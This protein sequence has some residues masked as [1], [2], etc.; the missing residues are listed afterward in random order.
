[1]ANDGAVVIDVLLDSAKAMTEYNK[2]GSVMSGTGSKIGSALKAGTAAAIAGTA[3]VG[4]AAVGIGKQVLASYADYEQL[5]GGVDTLFGNASKT[6]Q[7]FADNAY[8]TAGLSA[9][10]YM[11]TVTGFSASMVA[12]LK[13][14]TA[15]AADYSNQAVVDM[16]DNA[17]KMGSNIGDIQ[18]AY[19]GFAKQNYTML[20]NLK[21]GYGGTQ[22]E[23]KRLLSD[24]EKF[25]GQKY[26][27]SSFADVTQAIHVVQTQMGITGTTA[28][29]A[30]S[31]I[32]GSI[33]STKAAYQN[34][35]TG[36]GS[37]NANIKQ[38]V[39]NLMGSL[40]NVI[41]N[42]TPIIGNLIT[43]LPPVIT[44]LLSSIAKLLPTL[45]ST[46]ASLFGTLLSTIV[47]LLPTVI[48]SFVQGILQIV[49]AIIQ[50]LPMIIN[51]GIQIIMAL[52]QGLVQALPTLIPQIVQAVLLIVNTLTQNLPLLITAAIQIIVAIVT[53]LAQAI[54][55][56][57]PAIV[58]AVFVMV[59]ALITN[60]PLLWSASIQIILAIIK[61]IVQALPQLLS[62]M[63]KTIP[64]LVNTIIN[65]LPMLIN[66]AIQIILAL[67][68][69]FVSATPQI[70][71]SMN[72]IMNNL[73]STIAGK[74]GEF[75]SKGVQII[76]SFVNGI[77]SGKN[78][79][80]VFRNFIK[81]IAGLFGLNTLYNQGSAIISGFFNGLKDKFEDVKSWVGGIGK[82]I[83]DH[84]GPI[85]YDRR[86]LIPHGGSIMEGLDEGLQDKFKKVQANVSSMANK[87]ADS[88]TGGLPS[89]D[90]ALNASVSSSTS[91]SQAQLVNSNNATLSEKIDKMGDRIDEMNQRKISIKV[92]GREVA[93]T[94]YDDFETVKT[95][96]DT[97][98]RMIGRKK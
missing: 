66:A 43:A 90:T 32:S 11:E 61:G 41:N 82:W 83:S 84:K 79:V 91:Y 44:G 87:L 25:S 14:D 88:L 22:E 76:G 30:A 16:A 3:A 70:L 56:L 48:P 29:E 15:K 33:D 38:L 94:I 51:A 10:A 31:T 46:I 69:G 17:N 93:E 68:S 8:K 58:N 27:I 60:L 54:P 18:N 5:V 92:N 23:M 67:I 64:L 62:Q 96:R 81:N 35:I 57:I 40:T 98:D 52:V 7:G 26:D 36:L 2:L 80:D 49:N 6:V 12:S 97:R 1:M 73:I 74:V 65:N 72:R 28:K 85:S 19:Q 53:G 63:E 47:K 77:I 71:S 59:D 13:G 9:N 78:P 39:D 95:S 34:L 55:Q 89:I 45:F 50:N 75:L 21:L 37:S 42:I 86:L 24:A 4:V 20:D